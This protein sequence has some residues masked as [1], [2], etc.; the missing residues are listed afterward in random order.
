MRSSSLCFALLALIGGCDSAKLAGHT[1]PPPPPAPVVCGDNVCSVGETC[2]SCEK[3]CGACP[4]CQAAPSCT[5]SVG[6][7]A[8]PTER[9]DLDRGVDHPPPDMAGSD[10]GSPLTPP[11]AYAG[12]CD[13]AQ[14]RVRLKSLKVTKH[15]GQLYCLVTASDGVREEVVLS[16]KTKALSDGDT[17][18]F[19][20][21]LTTFW[22]GAGLQTT[23]NNLTLTYGCY[24][25]GSDAW[26]SALGALSGAAG[27]ANSGPYGWAFGIASAGA[28]AAAAAAKATEGDTQRLN[29]QQTIDRAQLLDL[30]NGRSW[31]VRQTG[32]CGSLGP[33]NTC[34]YDWTLT[35]ETWGCAAVKLAPPT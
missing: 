23:T 9:Q 24:E 32:S 12:N 7:P 35:L 3:D 5:D 33:I 4:A 25:I 10:M 21:T 14:L 19:D 30:T 11:P 31:Q 15:G 20:P 2:T 22:G 16:Q 6:V 13:A 27:M 29:D 26:S 17:S 34:T 8:M 1:P 18:Y 28:A